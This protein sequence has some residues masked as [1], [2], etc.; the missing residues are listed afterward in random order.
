MTDHYGGKLFDH[1]AASETP[2]LVIFHL[3]NLCGEVKV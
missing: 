2:M 1:L 3:E